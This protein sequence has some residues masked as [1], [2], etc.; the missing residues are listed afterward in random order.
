M[1]AIEPLRPNLRL[2]PNGELPREL[3]DRINAIIA[4][5]NELRKNAQ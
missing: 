3:I 5:L 2:G 1:A 4:A